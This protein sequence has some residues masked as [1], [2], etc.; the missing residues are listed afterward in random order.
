MEQF[1]VWDKYR[2]AMGTARVHTVRGLWFACMRGSQMG[3][4]HG[5]V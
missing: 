3:G 1:K 4:R 2:K 5:V